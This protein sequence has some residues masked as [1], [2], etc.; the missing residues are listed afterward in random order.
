MDALLVV[1]ESQ[2]NA[3]Q[4]AGRAGLYFYFHFTLLLLYFL[5]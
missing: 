3:K 5:V 1:P 4:R 2:A